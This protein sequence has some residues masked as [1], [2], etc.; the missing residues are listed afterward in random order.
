MRAYLH[1]IQSPDVED[2]TTYEPSETSFA[3]FLQLLV[4][5]GPDRE[6]GEE[7]FNLTVCSP[8]WLRDA[9]QPVVGRHLLIVNRFQFAEIESFILKYIDSCEGD[10]WDQVAEKIGRL[11]RWEF[12]D[13]KP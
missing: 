11:G 3:V 12:E 6:G 10:D 9:V 13:Y 7:S 4:G 2:L 8:D 1:L 5:P